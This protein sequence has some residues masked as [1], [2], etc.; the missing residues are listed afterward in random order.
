MTL[1]ITSNTSSLS[2][3]DDIDVFKKEYQAFAL[4]RP[5]AKIVEEY[6]VPRVNAGCFPYPSQVSGVVT[7]HYL[8]DG[9]HSLLKGYPNPVLNYLQSF[10]KFAIYFFINK[11]KE[12]KTYSDRIH[13]QISDISLSCPD[14]ALMNK[15]L[16]VGY[17]IIIE[18]IGKFLSNPEINKEKFSAMHIAVFSL[19]NNIIQFMASSLRLPLN[20]VDNRGRSPLDITQK[21][22]TMQILIDA[23]ANVNLN[24]SGCTVLHRAIHREDLIQVKY[25]ISSKANMELI[26]LRGNTALRYALEIQCTSQAPSFKLI[27]TLLDAKAD[28]SIFNKIGKDSDFCVTPLI[29]ALRGNNVPLAKFVI[30]YSNVNIRNPKNGQTALFY[31]VSYCPSMVVP[32]LENKSQVNLQ[33]PYGRTPLFFAI[34]REEGIQA[35]VIEALL[36]AKANP[37]I[38]DIYKTTAVDFSPYRKNHVEEI[39]QSVREQSEQSAC[40]LC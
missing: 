10:R 30:P 23:G 15:T 19:D 18:M 1:S 37:Y 22:S 26:N 13:K 17:Q 35:P 20:L 3:Q 21:T 39:I 28:T 7:L 34:K 9:R 24:H 8:T 31:A 38:K 32:L 4:Y 36:Q 27:K 40:R 16:R 14:E 2:I 29:D 33:D 25:L 5:L 6:L 12:T 11:F